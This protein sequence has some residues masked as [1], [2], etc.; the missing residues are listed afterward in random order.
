[1]TTK[2]AILPIIVRI[3]SGAAIR[4]GAINNAASVE[5]QKGTIVVSKWTAN[6]LCYLSRSV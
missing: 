6:L 3:L 1:M 5:Y 2:K 4:T